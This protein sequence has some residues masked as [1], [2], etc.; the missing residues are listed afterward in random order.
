MSAAVLS[1]STRSAVVELKRLIR[2]TRRRLRWSWLAAGVCL[3]VGLVAATLV[4]AVAFD[5][6]FVLPDFGR[7]TAFAIAAG[8]AAVIFASRVLR[9]TFTR[10]PTPGV[11][12]RIERR[13]ENMHNRLLTVLDLAGKPIEPEAVTFFD[14]VVAQTSERV[15]GFD[16]ASVVDRQ[17]LHRA[18]RWGIVPTALLV[19]AVMVWPN[20]VGVALQRV[21]QPWADIPP[22]SL[23]KFAVQPGDA[24]A[25]L[26]DPVA[27]A[28]DIEGGEPEEIRIK[29]ASASG[30]RTVPVKREGAGYRYTIEK[31]GEPL[32]YRVYA[33]RTWTKAYRIDLVERPVL[34]SV[35][36]K[37][38][39]PK[40]LSETPI[41]VV[42]PEER[43]IDALEGST[44]EAVVKGSGEIAEAELVR[45]RE[46]Q[47]TKTIVDDRSTRWLVQDSA[48]QGGWEF[49]NW[50]W[51][52]S[53]KFR[54]THGEP[55]Q[56][57]ETRHGLGINPPVPIRAGDVF[58]THVLVD[59]M[60]VPSQ[61]LIEMNDGN[62]WEHR[63]YWGVNKLNKSGHD[64]AP[65]N[66]R[67]GDVPRPGE[68]VRL[69]IPAKAIGLD[70]RTIRELAFCTFGGGV[71]WDWLGIAGGKVESKTIHEPLPSTPLTASDSGW[72]GKFPV[73]G[74]SVFHVELRDS[75]GRTNADPDKYR[76][77]IQPDRPPTVRLLEPGRDVTVSTTKPVDLLALAADD[78]GLDSAELL[79]VRTRE[80]KQSTKSI[81][82]ASRPTQLER[83]RA[84][85]LLALLD[86]KPGDEIKYRVRVR[87]KKGQTG[88][89][90]EFKI[91]IS[92]QDQQAVDKV[93][94]RFAEQR[95][96]LTEKI[97]KLTK[98]ETKIA[99][100]TAEIAKKYEPQPEEKAADP[101]EKT[102]DPKANDAKSSDQKTE[103]QK[104]E[105][106]KPEGDNK[107]ADEKSPDSKQPKADPNAKLTQQERQE[108]RQLASE[109]TKVRNEINEA[110]RE[111][112]QL[113][114]SPDAQSASAPELRAM[115]AAAREMEKNASPDAKTAMQMLNHAAHNDHSARN[116]KPAAKATETAKKDLE[117]ALAAMERS[118]NAD[119]NS[120]DPEAAA[121]DAAMEQEHAIA[122]AAEQIDAARERM[123]RLRDEVGKE[124]KD[125]DKLEIAR[126]NAS[127][128]PELKGVEG[129]QRDLESRA[130]ETLKE[131]QD[132]LGGS[133]PKDL[134]NENKME[135]GDADANKPTEGLDESKKRE[136][137]GNKEEG[138]PKGASDKDSVPTPNA[139][140]QQKGG[141]KSGESKDGDK[142]GQ[143]KSSQ[144]G[145]QGKEGVPEFETLN[146]SMSKR[147]KS[148]GK[149][150]GELRKDLE[151]R[152][153]MLSRD[154]DKADKAL[155]GKS[156]ELAQ[157]IDQLKK[158][159]G[160][161]KKASSL[162]NDPKLQK[163]LEL[164]EK[165]QQQSK[166]K[167]G[168]AGG[169][170]MTGLVDRIM[171]AFK[172]NRP[173]AE[174][175]LTED[176]AAM[177][178]QPRDREELL[179]GAKA[180]TPESYKPY[181]RD[182]YNRLSE[183]KPK[184]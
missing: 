117:R 50:N 44:I 167:T 140:G 148:G 114:T 166:S 85:A 19:A 13:T 164:A 75:G 3:V 33:G 55:P 170:G 152:Q 179:Q 20:F 99:E 47:E 113:L 109:Q 102:A 159:L 95:K 35:A 14:A 9:P 126:E 94:D 168:K 107:N 34:E 177:K 80:N 41:R 128:D 176:I 175:S 144:G 174:T 87:D 138:P 24:S 146:K 171:P 25:L 88:L 78:L 18:V 73:D 27:L 120:D 153:E 83:I 127:N 172:Q 40:Y 68:W 56:N 1:P 37:V 64:A 97:E 70:G 2:A 12:L 98:S 17:S 173:G 81:W 7:W 184:Q 106:Q 112:K 16:P 132:A 151:D 77:R 51:D 104:T 149:K 165:A 42:R 57:H 141:E 76:V 8:I 182:Y 48:P 21:L 65:A 129:R 71:R 89:S 163:Q 28:V 181:V 15:R 136:G 131:V 91:T 119:R 4:I 66:L 133:P 52:W 137:E 142:E 125:Q 29:F 63:A 11:A 31:F 26:G 6:A 30:E 162:L 84:S 169:R 155:S 36:L 43:T 67:L 156:G 135:E 62:T 110:T 178:L 101:K 38:H 161:G 105:G 93:H 45:R 134:S 121:A 145:K 158:A 39:P 49:G 96:K 139:Q 154:L 183:T 53:Q 157:T 111:L 100:K 90:D 122:D 79:L 130:K 124:S 103:G 22:P 58:I 108:M 69:E 180:P 54:R 92:P 86:A 32:S 60:R 147:G 74:P 116:A 160:D 115:D 10:L 123:E 143:A 82:S 59:P 46:R 5:L 118:K 72:F 150:G 23:L 61:I